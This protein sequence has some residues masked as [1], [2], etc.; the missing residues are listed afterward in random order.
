VLIIAIKML[1]ADKG[2]YFGIVLGVTLA[3]LVITQQGAIFT[4]IMSRTFATVTDMGDPDIWVMDTKVQ[5]IDDIKPLQSTALGRVRS[6]EGVAWAAPLYKGMLRAR[7]DNGEFQN[8][9][10]LGLDD[11]TLAGGPPSMI[12]GELE[13]LR[14]S[15][16]VI[17][18]AIGARTRLAQPDGMGG[19]RPLRVGDTIEINDR[20]GV[21]VGICQSMRT[22]QSQP[23]VYTTYSRA[24]HFAPRERKLL[25]F[26]LVKAMQGVDHKDLCDRIEAASG[27]AAYT[28]DQWKWKTVM[29]YIENTGIPINFGIAV[30]LGLLIGAVIT[31]FMFYS[32]IADNIRYLGTLKA[33]GATDAT[34]MN[35]VLVQALIVGT[36]GF[37][38]GAGLASLFGAAVKRSPLAFL[39]PWQLLVVSGSAVTVICLLAAMLSMRRV[40]TLEPAMVFKG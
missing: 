37:G 27:L 11:A 4:G 2:K 22:F 13:F 24:T 36:I 10:V 29:F 26:V 38:L 32:F 28:R 21:V 3:S 34:L 39:I 1:L 33:M 30:S 6:V 35:M 12:E 18:D 15:D 40:M 25:S 9:V 5:Y 23:V 14:R 31:G 16:A 7:L 20:R 17:V 19:K 8:C